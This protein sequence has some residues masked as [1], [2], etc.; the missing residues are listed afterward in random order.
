LTGFDV[1]VKSFLL[2][3]DLPPP[4][5]S[6]FLLPLGSETFPLLLQRDTICG[7]LGAWL[8][9][10][11]VDTMVRS[12][13]NTLLPMTSAPTGS[14]KTTFLYI[15]CEL[16]RH[17][18]D[19][20]K[21]MEAHIYS[22]DCGED[23]ENNIIQTLTSILNDPEIEK[24][25]N[26]TVLSRSLL[27]STHPCFISFNSGTP[28]RDFELK[29]FGKDLKYI[30]ISRIIFA[31]V[32]RNSC[33][34]ET[35]YLNFFLKHSESIQR[36]DS[37]VEVLSFFKNRNGCEHFFLAVD[38][39][40]QLDPDS[41]GFESPR[42][43]A[44]IKVI[45]DMVIPNGGIHTIISSLVTNPF[46]EFLNASQY[47]PYFV[48]LSPLFESLDLLSKL[49]S[50]KRGDENTQIAIWQLLLS[51]GGH[52]KLIK[53]LIP[54]LL[55][56]PIQDMVFANAASYNGL[57]ILYLQSFSEPL[58]RLIFTGGIIPL[59]AI[60][61]ICGSS[62]IL[63][64]P[65]DVHSDYSVVVPPLAL[66]ALASRTLTLKGHDYAADL[67]PFRMS[68][69]D[70]FEKFI[71]C[72]FAFQFELGRSP[73]SIFNTYDKVSSFLLCS[74]LVNNFSK[75][76]RLFEFCNKDLFRESLP[77]FES[78][79]ISLNLSTFGDIK[80][81]FGLKTPS[82]GYRVWVVEKQNN[83]GFDLMISYSTPKEVIKKVLL[84]QCKTML[85]TTSD[86]GGKGQY[87]SSSTFTDSLVNCS[88]FVKVLESDH[89]EVSFLGIYSCNTS[90]SVIPKSCPAG[91][92]P[93]FYSRCAAVGNSGL[94]SLLGD[95]FGLAL[96]L[97]KGN[98]LTSLSNPEKSVLLPSTSPNPQRF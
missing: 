97:A 80:N 2:S 87:V 42:I 35:E 1:D 71:A 49:I 34:W 45:A 93:A 74:K 64:R 29:K 24:L 84:V 13:D 55:T 21:F 89:W 67:V 62:G 39:L 51:T 41:K 90:Q 61:S 23:L 19:V 4:G 12:K 36:I 25:K 50:N 63:S 91:V 92:S 88:E 43:Q 40:I 30:F 78:I 18:W 76:S 83:P 96:E 38:E 73:R 60:S 3:L 8:K 32:K 48:R 10:C 44:A 22:Q 66:Y 69:G 72:W 77:D 9:N 98:K 33:L 75:Q 20:S 81:L 37:F 28:I 65:S 47:T 95:S 59:S 94:F 7:V 16:F 5:Q 86:D 46:I 52:P 27:E 15:L 11:S 57:K 82:E 53:Q 85:V 6:L 79:S 54:W 70:K 68:S 14:G 17:K 56:V 58:Q 26:E 31:H